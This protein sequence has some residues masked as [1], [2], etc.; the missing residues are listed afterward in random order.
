M[1]LC[2]LMRERER[3]RKIIRAYSMEEVISF[4]KTILADL[5]EAYK[6]SN[7]NQVKVL[8]GSMY[9]DGLAWDYNG[10]LNHKIST[11]YQAIQY[12]SGQPV[13]SGAEGGT[14]TRTF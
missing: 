5:W 8:I 3:E 7:L 14:R 11:L 2:C 6:R 12:Y 13:P 4:M 10:T 1:D 9:P